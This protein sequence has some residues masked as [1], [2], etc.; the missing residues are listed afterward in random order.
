[1]CDLENNH[2]PFAGVAQLVE[3]RPSKSEVASSSLVSRSMTTEKEIEIL[4][5]E[6]SKLRH[7][8]FSAWNEYGSELC[9]GEMIRKEREI[10]ER[11]KEL[12]SLPWDD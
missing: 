9:A 7:E 10:E 11:I 12:E 8:N 5:D 4:K 6:L 3:R 2:T 1:V